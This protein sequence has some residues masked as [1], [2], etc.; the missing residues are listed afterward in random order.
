MSDLGAVPG[1]N[2]SDAYAI[3]SAGSIVGLD[4]DSLACQSIKA[5][6]WENGGPMVDLNTLVYPPSTLHVYEAVYIN[7]PGEILGEATDSSGDTRA[8][9]LVP[10]GDCDSACEQR[11]ADSQNNP[12][13]VPPPVSGGAR[14]PAFGKPADGLQKGLVAP[15]LIFGRAVAPSN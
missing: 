8:V 3:N 14:L 6:L 7:E 11:I 1:D 10:D 2:A 13:V 15:F 4:C 9:L 5:F 12:A